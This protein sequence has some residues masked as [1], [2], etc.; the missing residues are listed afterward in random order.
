MPDLQFSYPFFQVQFKK[1]GSAF[2]PSEADALIGGL[3]KDAGKPT[4]LWLLSH[5]WNNN[6]DEAKGLYSGL[7]AQIASQV[8]NSAALKARS[9]AICGVL[10]PSKKFEDKDLIPSGAAALDDAV[11]DEK[12][13][14]RIDDLKD[15][16]SAKGWPMEEQDTIAEQKLEQVR[17]SVDDW[18]DDPA[19]R[20]EVVDLI[21]SLLPAHSADGEDASDKFLKIKPDALVQNLSRALNPPPVTPGSSAAGLDPF[22][23]EGGGG[24]GG[25]A[26]F[27]DVLGGLSAGFLHLLNFT[28]YYTMKARAGDVGVNGVKPLMDRIFDARKDI[29]I[30]LI[31]H[32]FGCRVVTSAVNAIKSGAVLPKTMTLLQ[33]AFSH[34]GF[35][36]NYDGNKNDGA[37]RSVIANKKIR[38]PIIISHTRRDKAVGIA[39]PI[40]SRLAGQAAA[41]LGDEN[42]LYGGMGSNGAQTAQT[43]PERV[44][45]TLLDVNGTYPFATGTTSS[46]PYNLRADQFISGHS[47]IVNPQ[48]AYAVA[49]AI[50]S[51]DAV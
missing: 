38:G 6:M 49:T 26:S 9:F 45:G 37:F 48:V 17:Q 25:A 23:V 41:A 32:S 14:Q 29:R 5:G 33:G 7:T 21:R 24:L 4:D 43:T 42:D 39:Y 44:V 8:S 40:A 13:R 35:A 36:S 30:H 34:N 10:W 18:E 1:D 28:T 22:H 15:I 20:R 31:G 27:R 16:M 3:T 50:G 19:L 2:Q 46:K 47:D 51:P 11:T 12:L